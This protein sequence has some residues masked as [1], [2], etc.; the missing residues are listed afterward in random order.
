MLRAFRQ[1]LL[2]HPAGAAVPVRARGLRRELHRARS[3][4]HRLQRDLDRAADAD[5]I[6]G[7]PG[8]RALALIV[9]LLVGATAF[10]IAALGS[11][12]WMVAAMFALSGVGNSVYHP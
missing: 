12:F 4:L 8:Q 1:P 7:R 3:R 9:G 10:T 2:H 6:S 5:R 11:S